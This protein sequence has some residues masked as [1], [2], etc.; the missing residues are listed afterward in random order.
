MNKEALVNLS[1]KEVRKLI[2]KGEWLNDTMGVAEGFTQANLAIVP[3]N[4]ALE[5]MIFCQRNPKPC[6]VLDV[7]EPGSPV[8]ALLAPNADLTTDLPKYRVFKN[9]EVI[10]EPSD[11]TKYWRDDLVA[12]LI[13]CAA[14]FDHGLMKAGVPVRFIEDQCSPAMYIT[15]VNCIPSG[16]F[17]GNLV[18][19]MRP[20][21]HHLVVKAV[22]LTS[23]FPGVHG[24]P[25]QIGYAENIGIKDLDKVDFGGPLRIEPNE[26]PVF[27][28][29]GVTPQ[30][31]A[32]NAKLDLMITHYPGFT[33]VSDCRDEKF[34][35]I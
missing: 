7:T 6:P 14:T 9:G 17:S 26:V 28:A 11:I 16:P 19:S 20:I 12:F 34:A 10:D 27:W 25:I 29:C 18:V 3:K 30:V 4:V 2:R 33:F 15:N 31:A 13:G 1:G 22:Q 5:F 21:P 23:R 32:L 24:S 8:P 35:V